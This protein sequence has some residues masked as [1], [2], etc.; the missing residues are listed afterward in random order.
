[1]SVGS[2][3]FVGRSART[4]ADGVAQLEGVF[5]DRV[6]V[7]EMPPNVLHLKCV[8]SPLGED[9]VLLAAASINPSTFTGLEVLIVPAEETYAANAVALG[10]S[11][12]VAADHPR[13]RDTLALAGFHVLPVPT[14]EVRRADGS[15]TCQSILFGG[16]AP[17]SRAR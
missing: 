9:R 12:I 15:L 13:T 7:V 2:K 16:A 8:C 5:G 11:V 6:V 10:T 14:T 3:L 17:S 1:M 4:N